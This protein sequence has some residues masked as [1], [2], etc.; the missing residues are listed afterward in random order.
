MLFNQIWARY[1]LREFLKVF[2]LF[3]VCFY[4]L[5]V[6]VDYASHMSAILH[7]QKHIHWIDIAKYYSY[8]FA[9][10]AEILL[11]IG[12]LIAL[13]KTLTSLNTHH[14]LVALMAGGFKLKTLLRPFIYAGILCTLLLYLNEQFILPSAMQRLRQFE[15]TNKEKKRRAH[16]D[17]QMMVRTLLMED[18][19]LLLFQDYDMANERFFDAYWIRSVDD[20][21]RIKYLLPEKPMPIGLFVDHLTRQPNGEIALNESMDRYEFN[22]MH[23]SQE[24]LQSTIMDPE[25]LSL[26]ELYAQPLDKNIDELSERDSKIQTAFYWKMMIPWLSVLAIIAVAPFCVRYSRQTPLFFIYV[27]GLFGFLAFYLLL[28]AAQILAKR[29][30]VISPALGLGVP[31]LTVFTYFSWRF[32]KLR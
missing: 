20:I 5:Y 2:F 11:P 6:L 23:F 13:I 22:Q 21:Y 7:H 32:I 28:D 15:E 27:G 26:T 17:T 29:Q 31:F 4:G 19:S 30:V 24:L 3:L 16:Y 9:S 8:V 1:F 14:E 10:R 12:L 25:A 18:G